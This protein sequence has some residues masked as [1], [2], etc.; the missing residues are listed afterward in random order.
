MMN[1]RGGFTNMP[2][3]KPV[4]GAFDPKPEVVTPP[5]DPAAMPLTPP[6]V[7][8]A[9]PPP[10]ASQLNIDVGKVIGLMIVATGLLASV[11]LFAFWLFRRQANATVSGRTTRRRLV[12]E[13]YEVEQEPER[14]SIYR[15]RDGGGPYD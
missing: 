11:A 2:L 5:V 15:P 1:G 8:F 4:G 3:A 13:D 12:S 9:P 10:P 7:V 14:R 6:P